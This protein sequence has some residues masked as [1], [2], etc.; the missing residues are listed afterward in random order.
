MGIFH[1]A[2]SFWRRCINPITM[3]VFRV[4]HTTST[5]YDERRVTMTRRGS[6][7]TPNLVLSFVSKI[8]GKEDSSFSV[9]RSSDIMPACPYCIVYA[10][11]RYE[12]AGP[13]TRGAVSAVLCI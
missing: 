3:C 11:K 13:I 6:T 4:I 1:A 5:H 2:V 7:G 12:E 9:W 8:N 10:H